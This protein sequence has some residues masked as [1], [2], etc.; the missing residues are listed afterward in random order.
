MMPSRAMQGSH[1]NWCKTPVCFSLVP[2]SWVTPAN[3]AVSNW[4]IPLPGASRGVGS[5]RAG[6]KDSSAAEKGGTKSPAPDMIIE[7]L[8]GLG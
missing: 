3:T 7:S 4:H 2:H 6:F 8:N 5:V 1:Y